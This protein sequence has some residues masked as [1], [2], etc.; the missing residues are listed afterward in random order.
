MLL[1][2]FPFHF[3]LHFMTLSPNYGAW[4]SPKAVAGLAPWPNQRGACAVLRP[5]KGSTNP[6]TW[7]QVPRLNGRRWRD[8]MWAP[9]KPCSHR[10]WRSPYCW[11]WYHWS[12]Q[13]EPPIPVQAWTHQEAKGIGEQNSHGLESWSYTFRLMAHLPGCERNCGAVQSL[14]QARSLSRKHQRPSIRRRV[15]SRL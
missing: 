7:A 10:L 3:Y 8:R 13:F 12:E 15:F 2:S 1:D 4:P 5:L 6:T 11:S 14:R 9:Q